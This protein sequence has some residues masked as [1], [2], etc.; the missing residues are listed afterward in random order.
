MKQRQLLDEIALREASLDDARRELA[1]GELGADQFAVIEEREVRGLDAARQRLAELEATPVAAHAPARRRRRPLLVVALSCF[2][3]AAVGLVWIN[4]GLRQAGTSQT[5]TVNVSASQ[6][7]TQL[8]IEGQGDLAQNNALAALSAYDQVLALAPHNI[9]ALTEAGWL[10]F[11]AGSAGKNPTVVAAAVR[12][13]RLAVSLAPREAAPHL[14]YAI[15]AIAT[16]HNTKL[17]TL[18]FKVFLS[19]H[20]SKGQVAIA[21]PF[22]KQLGLRY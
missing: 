16:P 10:D 15:V 9:V 8:L 19:L 5:G 7:I 6:H 13:L 22:L 1:A 3:L 2:A 11:S 21:A 14:Y 12:D 4:S 18:E 17:A 20:P